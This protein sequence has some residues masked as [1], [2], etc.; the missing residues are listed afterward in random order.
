MAPSTLTNTPEEGFLEN[1]EAGL[2]VQWSA[3]DNLVSIS[4][5]TN[6]Q[7]FDYLLDDFSNEYYGVE[8]SPFL[9]IG[10]GDE[11]NKLF[12]AKPPSTKA[13]V[14]FFAFGQNSEGLY[15]RSI[16]KFSCLIKFRTVVQTLSI[17][18]I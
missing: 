9:G 2:A 13:T 3:E 18:F 4:D 1:K 17:T 12:L 15:L 16:I 8:K 5:Y 10:R 6:N 14:L 7:Q 11:L